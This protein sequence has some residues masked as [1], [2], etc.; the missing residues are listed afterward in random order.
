MNLSTRSPA[1]A[2]R[3]HARDGGG[4]GRRRRRAWPRRVVLVAGFALGVVLAPWITGCVSLTAEIFRFADP[5]SDGQDGLS[6][7]GREQLRR[8]DG[9][10]QRFATEPD[11]LQRKHFQDAFVRVRASYVRDVPEETLMDAAIE[12]VRELKAANRSLPASEVVEAGLDAM[13]RSL[14]PH[15]SYLNAQEFREVHVTTKGEFGGLGI[16]VTLKD[17]RIKVVSPIEGTPA[18][19]AGLKSGDAITHLDGVPVKGMALMQAVRRMRGPPGTK[20]RLTIERTGTGVFDVAITRAIIRIRSV[21][22]RVEGDIGYIRVAS[23]TEKVESGVAEAMAGING[24]LGGR[25]KGIVLD[26]RSNPGGLLGQSLVLADDFLDD[27][28]IV[29]VRGRA[30]GRDRY[31]RAEPGDIANGLPIVVLVDRGSA[32]ASE[33]VA[34]ALQDNGRAIV[35]G[36][37]SFGKGSVQTIAPL[38][39]EGG[40]RLTTALFYAPSGQTIQA[41]GV[42]PDI[43]LRGPKVEE[44]EEREREA[45]QPGFLLPPGRHE[46]RRARATVD[47]VVCTPVGE[48]KDRALGCALQL[49]RAGSTERFLALTGATQAPL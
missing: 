19:R 34:G 20:I 36:S 42:M 32:S 15:S 25:I 33:I 41:F 26:L 8:F 14:D 12:G 40:L 45:D 31:Y 28:T 24:L 1:T 39:V 48:R 11:P 6:E 2:D 37:R 16:E 10:F 17:D 38:P 7:S 43:V 3:P 9:V 29:S 27:G 4:P 35:M 18:F 49:L 13:L 46:V 23:F 47:E 30:R 21:R 5:F 44:A 22:W